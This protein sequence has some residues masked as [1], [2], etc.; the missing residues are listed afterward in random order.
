MRGFRRLTAALVM[1]ALAIPMMAST[2]QAAPPDKESWQVVYEGSN[3]LCGVAVNYRFEERGT[4]TG[5]TRGP[6][7][8]YYGGAQIHQ[9]VVWTNPDNGKSIT[10]KGSFVSKDLKVVAN[11]DGTF[12]V[13]VLAAGGETTYGPDG[14]ALFRNPGQT[15]YQILFGADGEW[16][17]DLGVIKG[18]TGRNDV[19]DCGIIAALLNG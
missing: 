9:T 8:L 4:F 1:A 7:G 16:L 3:D 11:A 18:S 15:R 6:N 12:T 5:K 17:E 2:A 10:N 19:F 13:T 14:K